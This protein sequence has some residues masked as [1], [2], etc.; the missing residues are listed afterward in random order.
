MKKLLKCN[1]KSIDLIDNL[2]K[3][4]DDYQRG[5]VAAL[6]WVEDNFDLEPNGGVVGEIIECYRQ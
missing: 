5:V 6:S 3:E 1:G 2:E 4:T